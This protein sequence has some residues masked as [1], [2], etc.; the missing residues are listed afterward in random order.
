MMTGGIRR[1]VMTGETPCHK[2]SFNFANCFN[3]STAIMVKGSHVK[4]VEYLLLDKVCTHV[5]I[6]LRF[7]KHLIEVGKLSRD[8]NLFLTTVPFMYRMTT[9]VLNGVRS[10][11]KCRCNSVL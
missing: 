2:M 6:F 7:V 5:S 10:N 1:D 8:G 3:T 11:Y 9:L 4:F